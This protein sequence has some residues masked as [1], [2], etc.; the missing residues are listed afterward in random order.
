MERE[1]LTENHLMLFI[2]KTIKMPTIIDATLS[3]N[4]LQEVATLGAGWLNGGT[5]MPD[6]HAIAPTNAIAG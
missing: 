5:G 1:M 4:T 6:S 2:L 3:I